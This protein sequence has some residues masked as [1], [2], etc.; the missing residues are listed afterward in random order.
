MN[1]NNDNVL[2]E[3]VLTGE[4]EAFK[5]LVKK[6]QKPI[7]NLAYKMTGN[8]DEASDIAQ[9]TFVKCFENLESFNPRYKFFSWIYRIALNESLNAISMKK[10][11]V[12][13][14]DESIK[15]SD[16]PSDIVESKEESEKIN[17]ALSMLKD[18]YKILIILKH[19]EGFTYDEIAAVQNVSVQK[20]KSRLFMA[21]QIL[22]DIL[23]QNDGL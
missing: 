19:Y 22:K 23:L 9:N 18:D 3:N 6:Y 14:E 7:Y 16:L 11:F 8:Y 1:E 13:V 10:R 17:N 21:R 20:V 12:D 5:E 2:V 15:S 4:V